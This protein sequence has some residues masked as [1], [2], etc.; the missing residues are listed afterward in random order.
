MI[1][2]GNQRGGGQALAA[3]LMNGRDNDHV[4]LHEVRGFASSDL[5][6]AFREIEAAA[7]A[8]KCQQPFFSVSLNPPKGH[9]ATIEDFEKARDLIEA[10]FPALK[11]QPRSLI[12]HEKEGRRHCHAVWS[13]IDTERSFPIRGRN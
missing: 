6:G 4:E 3:H 11:D 1:I 9:N 2:K 8:T 10:K 12:F 7:T 13:R 5:A